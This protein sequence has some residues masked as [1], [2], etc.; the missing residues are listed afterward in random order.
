MN[1][2][3]LT[4][5]LVEEGLSDRILSDAQ[6]RR[7][8]A[9]TDQRRYNLVNRA[10]K[11]GE[12]IRLRRGLYL[13]ADKF[14]SQPCHPYILAQSLAQGSYISLETAL[15]FHGWI[16]EAV[17]TT[18][19]V[20]PDAMERDFAH[21]DLGRFT[22][23]R[24]AIQ[25]GYFMELVERVPLGEQAALIARPIRALLDL[26]SLKKMEWQGLT[27][28]VDGMRIDQDLLMG[29]TEPELRTLKQVYKFKRMIG[30]IEELALALGLEPVHD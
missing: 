14:R 9:G 4:R 15:A 11:T 3:T 19:S 7:L 27:F 5:Q 22:F 12:L 30:F 28:L 24:L 25:T 10:M 2:Q 6:L 21:D 29:V 20:V 1:M 13:L 23:H 26:V 16:P 17:Y 18:A 8:V